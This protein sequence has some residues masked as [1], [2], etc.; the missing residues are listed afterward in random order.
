MRRSLTWVLLILGVCGTHL[1]AT[2]LSGDVGIRG[3]S[4][5]QWKVI[6]GS[7]IRICADGQVWL[8]DGQ[9]SS[10]SLVSGEKVP[11]FPS[12]GVSP[13]QY[14]RHYFGHDAELVSLQLLP[15]LADQPP[16][17]E[18]VYTL[19]RKKACDRPDENRGQVRPSD[20]P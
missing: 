14:I 15:S 17:L 18:L 1:H 9:C 19:G 3:V 4:G 11:A 6:P 13:A 20:K 2:D 5:V 12:A 8:A 7:G 16:I 10:R